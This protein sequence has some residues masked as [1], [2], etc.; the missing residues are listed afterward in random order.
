MVKKPAFLALLILLTAA[1]AQAAEVKYST[2]IDDLPL[3]PS[4][5][6]LADESMTFDTAQG[7]IV[8]TAAETP[9]NK[10]AVDTFYSKALPAL[11][12]SRKDHMVFVR[13]GEILTLKLEPKSGGLIVHFS[14]SPKAKK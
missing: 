4:M 3:M 11:G 2:T 14:I 7:R 9:S 6:E 8:E 10:Y 1:S 12:W 5:R 13:A